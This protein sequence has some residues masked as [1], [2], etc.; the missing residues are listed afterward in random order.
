VGFSFSLISE[1]CLSTIYYV[2]LVFGAIALSVVLSGY[3]PF[4]PKTLPPVSQETLTQAQDFYVTQ[5]PSPYNPQETTANN[6]NCGPTSLMMAFEKL[7]NQIVP[8]DSRAV[9]IQQIRQQMTGENNCH[10]WTYPAQVLSAAQARGYQ[11]KM[12]F[13][14]EQIKTEMA[15]HPGAVSVLN[16]NPK[17]YKGA[18]SIP[19][20]GGHF[21]LLYAID[22][23]QA[24]VNDPLAKTPL[25]L[26]NQQL[27]TALSLPLNNNTPAFNGGIVIWKK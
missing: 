23:Q 11:A 20:E 3:Q 18:L 27:Q 16:L 5:Y 4:S 2:G 9:S 8:T 25:L 21:A 24:V 22:N 15:K 6:A 14:L 13:E 19:Y 12:V 1:K 26:S 17:P 10:N 7:D